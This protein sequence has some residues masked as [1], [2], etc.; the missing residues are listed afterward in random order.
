MSTAKTTSWDLGGSVEVEASVP[1]RKSASRDGATAPPSPYLVDAFGAVWSFGLDEEHGGYGVMRDGVK[2]S[3]AGRK[4]AYRGG[5]MYLQNDPGAW[6]VWEGK[7]W[8]SSADP[9]A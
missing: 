2:V 3:G 5:R 6:F 9:L 7:G 8:L 4:L 1:R